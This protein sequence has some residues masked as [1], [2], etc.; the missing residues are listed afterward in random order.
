MSNPRFCLQVAI[1][2]ST[3]RSVQCDLNNWA[4]M[5]MDNDYDDDDDLTTT[6]RWFPIQ[7]DTDSV[8]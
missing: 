2:L 7:F 5:T 3:T 6:T 8:Y 4:Q 1:K